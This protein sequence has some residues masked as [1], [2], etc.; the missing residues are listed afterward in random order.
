M[1]VADPYDPNAPL[2]MNLGLLSG[3]RV[4]TGLRTF[5]HG[6]SPLKQAGNGKPGLMWTAGS[7]AGDA[8]DFIDAPAYTIQTMMQKL[9]QA[10]K[11]MIFK[12]FRDRAGDIVSDSPELSKPD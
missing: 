3:T 7:D 1:E 5:F 2:V 8:G 10:E 9:R 4:M 11:E 6:Y 12:E